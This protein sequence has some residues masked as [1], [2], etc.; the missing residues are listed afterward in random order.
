MKVHEMK[1]NQ[2]KAHLIEIDSSRCIG[3][4]LCVKDCPADNLV[5]TDKKA[6]LK[7]QDCIKCGHCVAI[8]PKAAVSMSGFEEPPIELKNQPRVDAGQLLQSLQARRSIRQFTS[9]PVAQ[10]I[11][12]RVIEAGRWTPTAK[13]APSVSYLVLQKKKGSAEA[14]AVHFFRKILPLAGLVYPAAKGRTIDDVFFFK[15]AP[16]AIAILSKDKVS[17]SLAASN[18]ALMAEAQGLGVLY[19]GF[20]SMAA[21]LSAPLRRTLGLGRKDKVVT[22][23]VLGYSAVSYRRTTQKDKALVKQM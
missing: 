9:Q 3:C 16:I 18:M 4:G 15:G 6:V 19:S 21:N 5:V 12:D 2:M 14:L 8:C 7:S 10:E 13:N 17:G 22:T 23:L 1:I 11:I 20:F